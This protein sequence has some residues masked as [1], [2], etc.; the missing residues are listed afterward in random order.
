MGSLA[1]KRRMS[2]IAL[3]AL[4]TLVLAPSINK[5]FGQVQGSGVSHWVEVCTT[6]GSKWLYKSEAGPASLPGDEGG[7]ASSQQHGDDCPY[8]SLSAAKF[9]MSASQSSSATK[10]LAPLP[11]LFYQ[12]P[13][14]LFAWA[15]SRSRA[16]PAAS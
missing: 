8:C 11:S 15:H 13:K 10:A 12:A 1:F 3:L 2:I 9:L 5:F 14:P 4:L 7:P 16:P 6:E